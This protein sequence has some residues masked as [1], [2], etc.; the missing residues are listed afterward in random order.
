MLLRRCAPDGVDDSQMIDYQYL[1]QLQHRTSQPFLLRAIPEH[2]EWSQFNNIPSENSLDRIYRLHAM[3]ENMLMR[4]QIQPVTRVNTID[5][6]GS[7][8]EMVA[9]VVGFLRQ[10]SDDAREALGHLGVEGLTVLQR[11]PTSLKEGLN[12]TGALNSEARY[13]DDLAGWLNFQMMHF[14]GNNSRHIPSHRPSS[15]SRPSTPV[16]AL[17]LPSPTTSSTV[18][19]PLASPA[20][21]RMQGVPMARASSTDSQQPY[22]SSWSSCGSVS[23]GQ[24]RVR[25]AGGE[26]LTQQAVRM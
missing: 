19:S 22:S 10:I 6:V 20:P 5:T 9:P 12:E 3:I 24:D 23:E 17:S 14:D 8:G 16:S 26:P 18:E 1:A 15:R 11:S 7:G 2:G 4:E 21:R 25:D 13:W